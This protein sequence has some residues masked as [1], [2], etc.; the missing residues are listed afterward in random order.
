MAFCCFPETC[1]FGIRLFTQTHV[2]LEVA[3]ADD[4][5]RQNTRVVVVVLPEQTRRVCHK[6]THTVRCMRL[7]RTVI[8]TSGNAID[9]ASDP[10]RAGLDNLLWGIV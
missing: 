9:P 5:A 10:T 6:H 7:F 1:F 2:T 8:E 3:Q 4:R